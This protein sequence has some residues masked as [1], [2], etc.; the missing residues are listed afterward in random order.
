MADCWRRWPSWIFRSWCVLKT[1]RKHYQSP[2]KDRYG[3]ET[4]ILP[5]SRCHNGP[6]EYL[7]KVRNIEI[8]M[9]EKCSL[10]NYFQK[11]KTIMVRHTLAGNLHALLNQNDN[12]LAGSVRCS[13]TEMEQNRF[14]N[15]SKFI[16]LGLHINTGKL[17][18]FPISWLYKSWVNR[19][20]GNYLR[21]I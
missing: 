3:R 16:F 21:S 4:K 13:R 14:R 6:S 19:E 10:Y 20:L 8:K 2:P 7:V 9:K 1:I 17:F 5:P 15:S 12:A 11:W 18:G